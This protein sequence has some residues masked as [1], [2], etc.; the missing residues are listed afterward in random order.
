MHSDA[1]PPR[2]IVVPSDLMRRIM[3]LPPEARVVAVSLLCAKLGKLRRAG[4]PKGPSQILE[5]SKPCGK[6]G[7]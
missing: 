2:S 3:T 5:F 7:S 4:E 1:S 6:K